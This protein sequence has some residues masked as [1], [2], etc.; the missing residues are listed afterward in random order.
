MKRAATSNVGG[1]GVARLFKM[2]GRQGGSGVNRGGWVRLKMAALHRSLYK[3]SFHWGRGG[4]VSARGEVAPLWLRH[5][6]EEQSP[7]SNVNEAEV[8]DSKVLIGIRN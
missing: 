2:R 5:W 1:R 7:M 3:V 6:L 4:R 8:Q